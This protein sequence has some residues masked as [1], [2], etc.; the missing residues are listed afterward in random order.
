MPQ[1]TQ[2]A[3]YRRKLEQALKND[4][5]LLELTIQSSATLTK[6]EKIRINAL[7]L[8]SHESKRTNPKNLPATD[9]ASD[10][11]LPGANGS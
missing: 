3:E 6:G 9:S 8:V 7:G 2:W 5:Q 10:N 4:A 11:N 1:D